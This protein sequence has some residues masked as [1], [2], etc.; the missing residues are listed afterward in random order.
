M[1]EI[2]ADLPSIELPQPP[3]GLNRFIL[4]IHDEAGYPIL[5]YFR[6]GA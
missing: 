6:D 2:R 3:Y 4:S 1:F 5:N